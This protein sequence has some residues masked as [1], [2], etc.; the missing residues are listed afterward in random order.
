[1]VGEARSKWKWKWAIKKKKVDGGGKAFIQFLPAAVEEII[2]DN[3]VV[4]K[5]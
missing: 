5:L 2:I 1:M 3:V 4:K